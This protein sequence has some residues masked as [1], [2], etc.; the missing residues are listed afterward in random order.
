MEKIVDVVSLPTKGNAPFGINK[1][2]G[3]HYVY[4]PIVYGEGQH[5]YFTSIDKTTEQGWHINKNRDTLYNIRESNGPNW[6]EVHKYWDK[7]VATSNPELWHIFPRDVLPKGENF[8][9]KMPDSF[10]QAYVRANGSIKQVKLEYEELYQYEDGTLNK[11]SRLG[12]KCK[13]V[14]RLRLKP[15]G[16][17]IV[18]PI[19][20]KLYNREE[21]LKILT[22]IYNDSYVVGTDTIE[23]WFDKNYPIK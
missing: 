7:V 23:E 16:D 15:N 12:G 14:E 19:S 13:P 10:I 5:L 4:D 11:V 8:I 21:V 18:H 1:Q 6:E 22:I 2:T 3:H 20:V 17:V 9:A